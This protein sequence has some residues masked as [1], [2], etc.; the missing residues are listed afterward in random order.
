ME[1]T[2]DQYQYQLAQARQ[3]QA[4]VAA[5]AEAEK[6]EKKSQGIGWF[7]FISVLFVSVALDLIDFFSVG[8]IGTIVGFF[9]NIFILLVAGISQKKSKLKQAQFRKLL[10]MFFGE[11]IPIVNTL[12]L[13]SI[14]W[15]WA[16]LASHPEWF[17]KL[18][19]KLSSLGKV[20]GAL[21]KIPTP[22]SPELATAGRVM[23]TVGNASQQIGNYMENSQAPDTMKRAMALRGALNTARSMSTK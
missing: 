10:V 9:G 16:F 14:M 22:V 2:F 7:K 23:Q 17:A 15:I 21:S 5:Q 6:Q 12:P 20:A 18:G 19:K 4:Q 8:T 13:R 11:S 3:Q 1:D